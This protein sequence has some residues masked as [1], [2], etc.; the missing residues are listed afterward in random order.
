MKKPL[1]LLALFLLAAPAAQAQFPEPEIL[2]PNKVFWKKVYATW[3]VNQ[4]AFHDTEDFRLLYRVVRV[5]GRGEHRNGV[6]RKGAIKKAK[7]ELLT[8]LANLDKKQPHSAEGLEGLEREIFLNLQGVDRK[9]KY[10]RIQTIRA[11]NGLR[12]RFSY[13]WAESGK[14][15]REIHRIL[16]EHGLPTDLIGVAFVESLFYRRARSHSGAGGIWQFMP[17]TAK[18]YMHLNRLVDER[19]DPILATEAAARYLATAIKDLETWPIAIT[20]YNFGRG[21]MARAVRAMG[22]Q[23]FGIIST[24]YKGKRFGFAAR[25]Y[26]ASFLA[27]LEIYKEGEKHFP[28]VKRR[29]AW[30]FDVIRLPFPVLYQQLIDDAQLKKADLVELNPA[31]NK[32]AKQSQE[33]LPYGYPLRVP[34]GEGE[35]IEGVLSGLALDKRAKAER[36]TRTTHRASGGESVARI[37]RRYSVSGRVLAARLGLETKD[38]PKAGEKIPIFASLCR[39][40][41]IPEA[42]DMDVPQASP[43]PGGA[44]PDVAIALASGI[45]APSKVLMPTAQLVRLRA[46][47]RR[48]VAVDEPDGPDLVLGASATASLPAVDLVLG[49]PPDLP[50][51]LLPPAT[52]PEKAP[53]PTS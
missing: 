6:N 14:F 31:L 17:Y 37:A 46:S 18:E 33:A 8:A 30:A 27:A 24:Q 21:G 13:G 3:S 28:G 9:D 45:G 25:N 32:V 19:Y 36:L 49:T 16:K 41:L 51:W 40:T 22:T 7:A 52:G 50:P 11:Q 48:V 42:R 10:R 47:P 39:Y 2:T 34:K 1:V 29:P 4:I 26:Y 12:E 15:E 20:S 23:D 5:P 43:L 38:R 53:L 35:R 44:S